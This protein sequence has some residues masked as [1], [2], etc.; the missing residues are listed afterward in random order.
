MT[1]VVV[2]V[3]LSVLTSLSA[4]G[5][6][7]FVFNNRV[8][9][10]VDARF[11]LETDPPGTSSVGLD[12]QVRLFGGPAGTPASQLLPLTPPSTTFR[13]AAGSVAAGYVVAAT[14]IIPGVPAIADA[15]VLVQVFDGQSWET[16]SHRFDHVYDFNTFELPNLPMG[17][18][19]LVLHS[20][21]EPSA[22]VLAFMG[23]GALICRL[24]A[25]NNVDNR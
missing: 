3:V 9:A 2:S 7:Q 17:T 11:V 8:G 22:F 20:V 25:R 24:R 18:S 5:Q 13:G 4:L 15:R 16:A 19:P 10:D 12:F 21:P 23:I 1:V 14:P 6:A